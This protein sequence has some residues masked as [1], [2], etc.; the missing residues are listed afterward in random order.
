VLGS[1]ECLDQSREG[2]MNHGRIACAIRNFL[3]SSA[4]V[5]GLSVVV[6]WC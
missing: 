5:H 6:R 3:N 4:S 2:R 1:E